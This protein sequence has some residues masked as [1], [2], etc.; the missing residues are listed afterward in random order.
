MGLI[1][2][3]FFFLF[4]KHLK[5]SGRVTFHSEKLELFR[6]KAKRGT[7][8]MAAWWTRVINLISLRG[9]EET[10]NA[11]FSKTEPLKC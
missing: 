8:M 10:Q 4:Q 7:V 11:F 9:C 5:C 3:F 1:F 6:Y 2:L